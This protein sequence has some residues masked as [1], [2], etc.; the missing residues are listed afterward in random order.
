MSFVN[1]PKAGI[2]NKQYEIELTKEQQKM[3][4]SIFKIEVEDYKGNLYSPVEYR[5]RNNKI[6]IP[7]FEGTINILYYP[8]IRIFDQN[9]VRDQDVYDGEISVEELEDLYD[10]GLNDTLCTM[11]IP[12]LVKANIWQE[13]EPEMAQLERNKALQ[14]LSLVVPAEEEVYQSEVAVLNS[15]DWR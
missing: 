3:I 1:E 5:K 6:T 7:Y 10:Y 13:V 14:N 11:V 4:Y 15:Y 9:D 12:L 8:A 2:K